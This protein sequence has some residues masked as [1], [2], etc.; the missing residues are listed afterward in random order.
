MIVTLACIGEYWRRN[1]HTAHSTAKANIY[2]CTD[3]LPAMSTR[4]LTVV[5]I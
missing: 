2:I 1:V 5:V 3:I 4:I